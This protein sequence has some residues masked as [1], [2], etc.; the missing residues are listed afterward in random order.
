M[1]DELGVL[2]R[3]ERFAD[4]FAVRGQPAESPGRLALVTV[5]LCVNVLLRRQWID[6]ERLTFPLTALPLALEPLS[7]LAGIAS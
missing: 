7:M 5:M 2:Y 1:R 4:L 3:D 6:H